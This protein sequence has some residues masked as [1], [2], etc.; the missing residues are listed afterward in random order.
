MCLLSSPRFVASLHQELSSLHAKA[1]HKP[2]LHPRHRTWQESTS[3]S[4]RARTRD[5]SWCS[6]LG[7]DWW[8]RWRFFARA[9]V[10]QNIRQDATLTSL[11]ETTHQICSRL[12]PVPK[13]VPKRPDGLASA[14]HL[15]SRRC[16]V[17]REP[18]TFVKDRSRS[19]NLLSV[20]PTLRPIGIIG[21]MCQTH[22]FLLDKCLSLHAVKEPPPR[23]SLG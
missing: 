3:T 13:W 16:D 23:G 4:R 14:G 12:G 7:G 8:R 5:R 22:V 20:D 19:V 9:K 11:K 15:L 18:I 6:P 2:P 17:R 10:K 21:L 1:I